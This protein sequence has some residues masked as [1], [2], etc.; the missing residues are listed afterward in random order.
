MNLYCEL[1]LWWIWVLDCC[2]AYT[3][4]RTCSMY[5]QSVVLKT[6]ST[7]K[8]NASITIRKTWTLLHRLF[9]PSSQ[10]FARIFFPFTPNKYATFKK[11]YFWFFDM[12]PFHHFLKA[13][14]EW[15]IF[16]FALICFLSLF[17]SFLSVPV[18]MFSIHL[19]RWNER[20]RKKM[21][22]NA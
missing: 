3:L 12:C 10:L 20:S 17:F 14:T 13:L 18:F 15:I 2:F 4:T 8:R 5:S 19:N 9:A 21:C 11:I 6:T 22:R 1:L 7:W 16:S